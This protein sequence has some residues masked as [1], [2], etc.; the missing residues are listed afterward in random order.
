MPTSRIA[1]PDP[2]DRV[3]VK[4]INRP[5]ALAAL[6]MGGVVWIFQLLTRHIDG[7]STTSQLGLEIAVGVVTYAWFARR[8]I[9]WLVGQW[10]PSRPVG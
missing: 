7:L 6:A 8:E 10:L 3:Q 9:R 5:A 2:E 1:P 4:T